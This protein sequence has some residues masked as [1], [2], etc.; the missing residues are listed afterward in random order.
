MGILDKLKRVTDPRARVVSNDLSRLDQVRRGLGDQAIRYVLDGENE[1]VLAS[2]SSSCSGNELDACESYLRHDSPSW[3]RRQLLAQQNSF[4]AEFTKRYTEVLSATCATLPDSACGSDKAT[5]DVR[6]LFSEAFAGATEDSNR[7]PPK[8]VPLTN[9]GLTLSRAMTMNQMLGGTVVDLVDVMYNERSRYGSISGNL[10]RSAADVKPLLAKHQNDVV[11]AA[12]RLTAPARATLIQDLHEFRL[13]DDPVYLHFVLALAGDSSKAVRET[14]RSILAS[15]SAATLEPLAAEQL[16]QGNVNMRAG[17]VELLAMLGTDSALAA[18]AEHKTREKTSRVLSAIDTALTVSDQAVAELSANDDQSAYQSIGGNRVEIPELQP[19]ADGAS[20][21]FGGD[22]KAE[23]LAIIEKENERLKR[24]NEE[25][26]KRGYN[27]R[28]PMI[29]KKIAAQVVDLFNTGEAPRGQA[30]QELSAFLTW[31]AGTKWVRTAL[32]RLSQK[33]TLYLAAA[34]TRS[35]HSALSPYAQGPFVDQV[36]HFMNGPGGD[37]RHLERIDSKIGVE[38]WFGYGTNRKTRQVQKGDFLRFVIQDD[39][40]YMEP[41]LDNVPSD[42]LWPYLAENLDVIDEAFGLKPTSVIKLS[43]VG[44]IRALNRLPEA[45]ARYFGPLL[46][47]ATGETKSG[48]AEARNMLKDAPKVGEHIVALLDDSRQAIRAGAAEWIAERGESDAVPALKKR[49]KKEKSELA[50]AAILTALE[51]FGEDLSGFIGPKALLDEAQAGL[52]KA[53]LD[54]LDWLALDH[55]PAVHYRSKRRV[56]DEVLRWWIFLAVKLKQPGGNAL[57]DIYLEQLLPQ[58]AESLSQWLLDSWLNY[59]TARPTEADGNAYAKQHVKQRFQYMKRWSKD[60]T[61]DRAFEDLKRE[62]MSNYLN[63][64]AAT[65]GLL[66][67]AGHTP[68]TIAADRVRAYLKQHGSRTSQASALLEM[69]AAMADPVALQV[70]I[71][72]ATRLKQKGVQKFAGA[73]VEKVAEAR[74][75]TLDELAD[76]TIPTAGLDDNGIIE[77]PCGEDG[78]RY[79]AQLN[80]SLTLTLRN[81]EGKTVKSLPGG[82]DDA[83]KAAKKQLSASRRELK[84]VISMQSARLYEALCAGRTWPAA[85]WQRD[86]QQHPVMRRLTE[87]VVWSGMDTD[88]Q[89]LGCFR[90]TSEGDFTNTSDEEVDISAYATVRLAYGAEM[91][92]SDAQAWARHLEDYEIAPLFT[93]FGRSML[94]IEEAQ[95]NDTKIDDRK[96]WVT[97]TFTIRGTAAKLGYERGEA[98]DG[99]YFNE[100]VK[101]FQSAGILAVVEFSGNCLPEENVPAAMISLS[102]ENYTSGRRLGGS[103]KLDDVPP[104]LLSEC[105]NDYRSMAAKGAFDE[106]WEQKMPWM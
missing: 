30:S 4:D 67:L 12:S 100:Y 9:K 20:A 64:G 1:T 14:A 21:K 36:R 6:L 77:L 3:P 38:A 75:W 83:T 18:L 16:G 97:D 25:N 34:L 8:A 80:E 33:R 90:P 93:Q 89:V 2:L 37:L 91:S 84:Q 98:M 17:M 87:R 73:L 76:R 81:P 56:P 101:S 49:L 99:G 71:S 61:K 103:V 63:S 72:A 46:E 32:A 78:K 48:R 60:Y 47:A 85:D 105:W 74:N 51:A 102:F 59:D 22:D 44:A 86:L 35:G 31:G 50:K 79:D 10:Y 57:F 92:E 45:P 5:K 23:L 68:A 53:K 19:L 29:K 94:T 55:L 104:V 70:V 27:Y 40:A 54:K 82:Q 11:A 41:Q 13:V 24:H 96:G 52:K 43:R 26:E 88:D 69:L 7:W 65:K 62:F 28:A 58:D 66:A 39:Y 106:G 95:Q 15:V 42:S